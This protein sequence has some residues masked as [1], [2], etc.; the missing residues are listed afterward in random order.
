[1]TLSW[2]LLAGLVA[3]ALVAWFWLDS[4]RAREQANGAAMEACRRLGLQFLDGTVAFARLRPVRGM[5][6]RLTFRRSYVFDYT[7]DSI[8]RRQGFVVIS[9]ARVE[10]VG[11]AQDAA[12][13]TQAAPAEP[14]R[15]PTPPGHPVTFG[16]VYD[17]ESWRR[18]TPRRPPAPEDRPDDGATGR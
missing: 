15:E 2:P 9:G 3:M 13:P 5:D 10:S 11:F 12:A 6:G 4:L 18:R 16:N 8:A 17:L 1:M 7:A 14:R